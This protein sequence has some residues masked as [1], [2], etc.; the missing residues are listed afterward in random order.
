MNREAAMKRYNLLKSKQHLAEYMDYD[1]SFL[2]RLSDKDLIYLVEFL[3][4]MYEGVGTGRQSREMDMQA[5]SDDIVSANEID[6][7]TMDY[8]DTAYLIKFVRPSAQ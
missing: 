4:D 2:R 5:M 3:T 7:R 6:E 8:T 1:P